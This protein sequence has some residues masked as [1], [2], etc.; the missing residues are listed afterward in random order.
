ME[1]SLENGD[2]HDATH[3]IEDNSSTISEAES[4]RKKQTHALIIQT[5]SKK[6]Q[7][8][9]YSI[10]I[11]TLV[12]SYWRGL[13]TLVDI[14]SC[15]QN[16]KATLVN[17]EVFCF[18]YDIRNS[19]RRDSAILSLGIG[20]FLTILGKFLYSKGWLFHLKNDEATISPTSSTAAIT[21]T[22]IHVFRALRRILILKIFATGGIFT[23]RGLW[24]LSDFLIY[25]ENIILSSWLTVSLGCLGSLLLCCSSSLCAAPAVVPFQD[26]S[27]GAFRTVGS[28]VRAHLSMS[29]DSTTNSNYN[30]LLTLLDLVLTYIFLPLFELWFYRGI[31]LLEDYYL[32]G[33]SESVSD[34]NN[35]IWM[36]FVIFVICVILSRSIGICIDVSNM[37]NKSGVVV[38]HATSRLQNVILGLGSVSFWRGVWYGLEVLLIANQCSSWIS[39]LLSWVSLVVLGAFAN[40]VFPPIVDPL[41]LGD[42]PNREDGKGDNLPEVY[43]R[44]F[45]ISY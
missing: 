33:Y 19:D 28:L 15:G 13:W 4:D 44:W 22:S 18:S 39:F 2:G 43:V 24:Y 32:W 6:I 7:Q 38:V 3:A 42:A 27:V 16:D 41:S 36:S 31:W 11:G 12:V 14:Y 1:G 10:A 9:A 5:I 23:W 29:S 8:W 40:V 30:H 35:S 25:S 21:A 26:P 34:V 20:Y 37:N 45:G 17:G